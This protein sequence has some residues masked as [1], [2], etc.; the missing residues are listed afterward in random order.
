[1]SSSKKAG[2][3]IVA[4]LSLCVIVASNASATPLTVEGGGANTFMTGD[5]DGGSHVVTT[6][7]GSVTCTTRSFNAKSSGTIINEISIAT[8]TSGCTAFGFATMHTQ[9]NGC[10]YT[11]TTPTSVVSGQVTWTASSQLH[12][13][14]PAGKSIEITPTSFGVSIC[15]MFMSTQTPTGGHIVGKSVTGSK[16]MDITLE[17]TMTGIHYTGTGSVCGNS[18][19][20]SDMTYSGNSTVR[21]FSDEKHTVQ[22]GCKFS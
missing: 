13:V 17:I 1:M 8:T 22:V 20:H 15:T 14:C 11:A 9:Q 3:G 10:V 19:T 2:L 4:A 16:P 21:C 12:L 5:Q 6:P 7:N 18:E